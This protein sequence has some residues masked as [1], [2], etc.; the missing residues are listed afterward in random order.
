MKI[1]YRIG[2][3]IVL[4]ACLTGAAV[5]EEESFDRTLLEKW[6]ETRR[7][8]SKEKSDWRIARQTLKDR[9]GLI[10]REIETYSNKTAKASDDVGEADDRLEEMEQKNEQLKTAT[11][12]LENTIVLMENRIGSLLERSPAPIRDKVAPLT[13]RMPANPE[14][15]DMALSER[16][17]NVIGI[18][19]EMN[20]FAGGM[21]EATE[22]RDLP[23][24]S[25]AEVTVLYLGFGQ[26]YYCNRKGALGGVG[27]PAKKGWEWEPKNDFAGR[28]ADTISIYRNEKPA[29]YVPLPVPPGS[30]ETVAGTKSLKKPSEKETEE[31]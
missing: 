30:K 7:M 10:R 18:L 27:L 5:A 4:A 3:A 26:A 14:D 29:A 1:L 9:I 31:Q 19:N 6:V 16:F 25:Q 15:T 11:A 20:K 12:G 2:G 28:I 8:I 22:V 24:G 13:S 17:Q 23:D 21:T